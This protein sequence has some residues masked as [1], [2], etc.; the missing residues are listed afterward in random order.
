M[1]DLL[2]H[3]LVRH[4]GEQ[5]TADNGRSK[6]A[7]HSAPH[8]GHVTRRSSLTAAIRA[9]LRRTVRQCR[10]RHA[11]EQNT[12][13]DLAATGNRSP[14]TGHRRSG[15]FSAEFRAAPVGCGTSD[16]QPREPRFA[17]LISRA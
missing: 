9:R 4:R 3:A 14:Q 6:P 10:A 17:P 11:G 15:F 5:N 13:D 1:S 12:I 7:A 8:C 2:R 16:S